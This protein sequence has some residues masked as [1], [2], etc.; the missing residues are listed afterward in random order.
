MAL[1]KHI[2]QITSGGMSCT[3]SNSLLFIS[4][5]V[6]LI[7]VMCSII[8]INIIFELRDTPT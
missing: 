8:N 4:G 2:Y 7:I 5:F 6:K 1:I 3:V